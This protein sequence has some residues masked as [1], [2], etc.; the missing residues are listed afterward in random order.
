MSYRGAESVSLS[1][2]GSLQVQTPAGSFE[3][4]GL[5][6]YQERD[7]LKEKVAAEFRR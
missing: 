6:A 4:G 1:P 3:E 7:G 5:F 2:A